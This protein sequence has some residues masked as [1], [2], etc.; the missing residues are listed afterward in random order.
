[1]S[2]DWSWVPSRIYFLISSARLLT[3]WHLGRLIVSFPFFPACILSSCLFWVVPWEQSL[4]ACDAPAPVWC[5]CRRHQRHRADSQR[6]DGKRRD[7][8]HAGRWVVVESR[9][10]SRKCDSIENVSGVSRG[11]FL[12][13]Q[14]RMPKNGVRSL[15]YIPVQSASLL[16]WPQLKQKCEMMCENSWH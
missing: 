16:L 13:E 10:G 12:V 7:Q 6:R 5:V 1:M 9:S 4:G 3:L 15:F 8:K 14:R 2:I 11:L